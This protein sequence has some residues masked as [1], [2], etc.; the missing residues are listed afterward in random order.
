MPVEERAVFSISPS[1][2][3]G[4]LYRPHVLALSAVNAHQL[5]EGHRMMVFMVMLAIHDNF[6]GNT[7][8]SS[9]I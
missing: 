8:V 9:A 1:V 5:P 3:S 6:T 7:D 2:F 4:W